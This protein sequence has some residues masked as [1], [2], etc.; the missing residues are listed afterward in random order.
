MTSSFKRQK[1]RFGEAYEETRHRLFFMDNV[2]GFTLMEL[3][4]AA[5]ILAFTITGLIQV[6]IQSSAITN[7]TTDQM[8]A[9]SYAENM[10]ETLRNHDFDGVLT[11][12][13]SAGTLGT[14]FYVGEIGG[15]CTLGVST[16]TD[17]DGDVLV[18]DMTVEWDTRFGEKDSYYLRTMR[19]RR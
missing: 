7:L 1:Q 10:V 5:A 17:A 4:L 11:D 2:A 8:F 9:V 12:Y 19:S 13:S 16:L 14:S 15:T 3:L 6:F 18:F